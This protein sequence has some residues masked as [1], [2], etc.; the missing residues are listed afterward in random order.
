MGNNWTTTPIS[1]P[2]TG[3]YASQTD[4]QSVFGVNNIAVWSNRDN[5]IPN[6][7][8]GSP[9]A[10]VTQIQQALN[11]TDAFINWLASVYKYKTPILSTIDQ[12]ARLN[13][14]AAEDAGIELYL[15]R[16]INDEARGEAGKFQGRRQQ[17][18]GYTTGGK[19]I[20][21]EI[22][23]FFVEGIPDAARITQNVTRVPEVIL[24][25]VIAPWGS[26]SN[27]IPLR[28]TDVPTIP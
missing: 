23:E 18:R 24:S 6:N 28:S 7:A 15:G 27:P 9:A 3:I 17:L 14:L 19:K 22:E 25:P 10:D 20:M 12:W 8:D 26:G 5:S 2:V 13:H 1:T 21:G 4:M 16:G 11:R